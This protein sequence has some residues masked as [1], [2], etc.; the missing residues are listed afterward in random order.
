VKILGITGIRS[1][2]DLMSMLYRR[3]AGDPD[4]DFKLLV[5]GAHLSK[6]YGYSVRLIRAD[7]I[8]ILASIE[9]LIDADTTSSRLKSAS[10]MLQSAVD[11]VAQ[12]SPDLIIYAGDREEVWMGATIGA[13]LEIPTVH[14]YGGDQI[15]TGHVDNAIRHATSK[16]STYHVVPIEEHRSRL[17]AIG[18]PASRISVIGSMA[19]DNFV[20]QK[21]F[22]RDELKD[23]IGLPSAMGDYAL[24]LFHPEP[25]ERETAAEVCRGMLREIKAAGLGACVGYP[26]IDPS[27][28]KI[29]ASFEEF[30]EEKRFYFYKNLDRTD[31]ISLYKGASMIIGNSSSGIVEAASIPIPAISVGARQRGR[32]AG[33]NVLAADTDRAAIRQAIEKSRDPVFLERVHRMINPYGDGKSTERAYELLVNTDFEALRLKTEDP[34]A[35]NGQLQ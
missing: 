33:F 4:L 27:N 35:I 32:H 20:A 18:E 3:L 21:P 28:K 5:G 9:S 7:A 25:S 1:D 12:W 14:F 19:L 29:I 6:T 15:N 23:R 13:Y 24:V 30:K 31:F 17:M 10:I 34:L 11:T 16:L 26:N 22:T 2:Y 8:P